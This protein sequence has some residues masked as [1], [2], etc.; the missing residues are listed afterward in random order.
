MAA[1][2]AV[3]RILPLAGGVLRFGRWRHDGLTALAMENCDANHVGFGNR[4]TVGLCGLA[5]RWALQHGNT[6]GL[7]TIK[8][9]FVR[10]ANARFFT[11]Q[12]PAVIFFFF[13]AGSNCRCCGDD[14]LCHS[15]NDPDDFPGCKSVPPEVVEAGKIERLPKFQDA[16]AT[17]ICLHV[18]K[19]RRG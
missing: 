2:A 17:S 15:A 4:S 16:S 7:I 6:N 10:S 5:R 9:R 13:R 14:D 3:D 8:P 11:Y 18:P 12:L 1:V 19:F